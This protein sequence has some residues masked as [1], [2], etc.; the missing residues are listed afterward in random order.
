MKFDNELPA[1][2]VK[3][4]ELFNKGSFFD[5]HEMLEIAWKKEDQDIRLVYQAILQLGVGYYHLQNGNIKGAGHLF[6]KSKRNITGFSGHYHR[7]DIKSIKSQID[8]AIC[9]ID[10][11]QNATGKINKLPLHIIQLDMEK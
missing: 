8:E 5:A 10:N 1:E 9:L 6:E 7:F 2:V 4:I 11:Q 3:G